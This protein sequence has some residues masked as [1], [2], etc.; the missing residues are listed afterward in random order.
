MNFKNW[1][2]NEMPISKFQ[3]LGQW[4]PNAKR[5]YGYSKSDVGI[6][7]NPKAV[8]KIHKLWSNSKQDFEF[9]FLRSAKAYKQIEVGEVTPEWVK[10]NLEI[11]IQPKEDA[12]NIIFTQNT[13]AEKISLTAWTIAHRLGHAIRRNKEFDIYF[14]KEIEKDFKEILR[15]VYQRGQLLGQRANYG[16]SDPSSNQEKD[17]RSLAY[18]VGTMKSVRERNLRNFYEFPYELT[19]QY[20]ITGKIK[21]NPLPKGLIVKK[22]MAWGKP[23]DQISYSKLSDEEIKEWNEILD[24]HSQKY[25]H[26][27]DTIFDGLVGRIFVM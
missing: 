24:G 9:Y 4:E 21:F 3:L 8:N 18:A 17:L 20:I 11:D 14:L 13:G 22:R 27:L 25:E 1:I 26:Y 10:Q 7:Q 12:I 6:L 15:S 2:L 16:Y 19:A 23:N 5:A